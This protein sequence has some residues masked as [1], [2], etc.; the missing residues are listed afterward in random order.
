[1]IKEIKNKKESIIERKSKL[2]DY[3]DMN[4]K[5]QQP[6]S[7]KEKDMMLTIFLCHVYRQS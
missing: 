7:I 2:V 4:V 5:N 1:M 6:G 3:F